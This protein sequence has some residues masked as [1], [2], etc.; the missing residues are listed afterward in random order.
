MVDAGLV[1]TR[2]DEQSRSGIM[3]FLRRFGSEYTELWSVDGTAKIAVTGGG[4]PSLDDQLGVTQSITPY[5]LYDTVSRQHYYMQGRGIP[6][7]PEGVFDD[8][9]PVPVA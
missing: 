7:G 8:E 2:D 9:G 5:T 4:V 3:P 1:T 6:D